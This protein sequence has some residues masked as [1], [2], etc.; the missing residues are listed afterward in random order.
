MNCVCEGA[1][2]LLS[3]FYEG[4]QSA[5]FLRFMPKI[6]KEK[7]SEKMNYTDKTYRLVSILDKD[8][9][10]KAET[11]HRYSDFYR[12]LEGCIARNIRE[13]TSFYVDGKI[14]RVDVVQDSSGRL[15][16]RNFRTSPLEEIRELED[17]GLKIITENSVYTFE[18]AD[19]KPPV[20]Q[21]ETD[22]IEL[23]MT[24]VNVQFCNGFIYDEI[25]VPHQLTHDVHCGMFQDSVLIRKKDDLMGEYVCRYFP[26]G[27][28]IEFYD[29]IYHQQDYSLPILIHNTGSIPL[30]IKFVGFRAVWTILPG[31]SKRIQPFCADGADPGSTEP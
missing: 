21:D 23:Y 5:P 25:K 1:L 13:C 8:G 9:N 24:D 15:I 11:S 20:Y 14:A 16:N 3:L 2:R 7:G 26:R 10:R 18:P 12:S 19:L 22:L 29:T 6:Q 31:E 17:G 4:R 30:K 27:S 28:T